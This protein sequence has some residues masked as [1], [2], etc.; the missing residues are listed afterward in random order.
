MPNNGGVRLDTAL[1]SKLQHCPRCQA[2]REWLRIHTRRHGKLAH[3]SCGSC[4]FG[5]SAFPVETLIVNLDEG[6]ARP[7][8]VDAWNDQ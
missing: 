4:G 6:D 2:D 5:D 8:A 7:L 1:R 3:I